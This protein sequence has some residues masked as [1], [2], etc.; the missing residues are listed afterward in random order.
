MPIILEGPDCA[1]K[2]TMADELARQLNLNII[3]M[4]CN[5]NQSK[6]D[7][8]EKLACRH[9]VIDRCWIS[10]RI[11]SKY[12]GRIPRVDEFDERYLNDFCKQRDIQIV[13]LLPPLEDIYDRLGNRGDEFENVVCPNIDDI[14]ADY[15]KYCEEHP[16]IIVVRD[17]LASTVIKEVLKCKL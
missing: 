11:Y 3:K 14:Y 10:E 4:T 5:G 6:S 15:E 2:S 1:G 7:Y 16:Q 17:G 9:V 8:C 12:F 13:V